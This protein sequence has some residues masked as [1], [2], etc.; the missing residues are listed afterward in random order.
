MYDVHGAGLLRGGRGS[1]HQGGGRGGEQP[2]QGQGQTA[3]DASFQI[4]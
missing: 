3:H 4:G 1:G 2:A